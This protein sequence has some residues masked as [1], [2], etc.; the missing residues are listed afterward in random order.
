[1]IEHEFGGVRVWRNLRIPMP[2][3]VVLACDVYLPPED[4]DALPLPV[5][6]DYIPYRKDDVRP[7]DSYYEELVL[8]GYLVAR[9]D[10]R[11]RGRLAARRSTSTARRNSRM[12]MRP[13]SGL[14]HNRG[15]TATW[16]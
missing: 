4:R 1:M 7:G 14:R 9:V 5:V 16:R 3:G 15:A 13:S 11:E 12:G 10:V 6:L 2:D 8:R